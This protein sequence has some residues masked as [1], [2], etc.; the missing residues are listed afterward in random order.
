MLTKLRIIFVLTNI[1]KTNIANHQIRKDTSIHFRLCFPLQLL[2]WVCPQ[3]TSHRYCALGTLKGSF[4]GFRSVPRTSFSLSQRSHS[5]HTIAFCGKW[6][7]RK[8]VY[9]S[10]FIQSF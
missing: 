1:V 8:N 4:R 5:C 3:A 10:T 6:Y 9:R 2:S 7:S